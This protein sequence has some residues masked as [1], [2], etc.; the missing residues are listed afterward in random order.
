[1]SQFVERFES[2]THGPRLIMPSFDIEFGKE[3]SDARS[4]LIT[5]TKPL[6]EG[7]EFPKDTLAVATGAVPSEDFSM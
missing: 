6:V 5:R 3:F 7:V 2:E 1:M 4:L